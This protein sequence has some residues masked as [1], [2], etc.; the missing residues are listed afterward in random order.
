ML[1]LRRMA[2]DTITLRLK[3]FGNVVGE[4]PALY[5]LEEVAIP[6]DQAPSHETAEVCVELM[7]KG[8]FINASAL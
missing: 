6:A 8:S 7:V 2:R 1:S 3:P 4:P 5:P